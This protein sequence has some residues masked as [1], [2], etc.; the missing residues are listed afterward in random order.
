MGCYFYPDSENLMYSGAFKNNKKQGQGVSFHKN[1][2]KNYSGNFY[3]DLMN[4]FGHL[5]DRNGNLKYIGNFRQ[6]QK[7]GEGQ[8]YFYN[9]CLCYEGSYKNDKRSGYGDLYDF[10]SK[11]T[12]CGNFENDV[13]QGSGISYSFDTG[14]VIYKGNYSQDQRNG[15]GTVYKAIALPQEA[16]HESQGQSKTKLALTVNNNKLGAWMTKF[17]NWSKGV[18]DDQQNRLL[19]G[20]FKHNLLTKIFKYY[21]RNFWTLHGQN[22]SPGKMSYVIDSEWIY[23]GEIKGVPSIGGLSDRIWGNYMGNEGEPMNCDEDELLESGGLR[24][25]GYGVCLRRDN[26]LLTYEG[27]W[28]DGEQHGFGIEYQEL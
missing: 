17:L 22:F 5:Y 20:N 14:T 2:F 28:K 21:Q 11:L 10:H 27:L 18:D 1:G 9:K 12:Y 13:K 24:A 4:G 15:Y 6:N 25:E 19:D 7:D 8:Y 3:N 26:C 23:Y 16:N